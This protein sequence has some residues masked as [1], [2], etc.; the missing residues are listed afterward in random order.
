MDSSQT[1]VH[2]I[3]QFESLE[4][5]LLELRTQLFPEPPGPVHEPFLAVGVELDSSRL[6]LRAAKVQQVI[7][8]VFWEPLPDSPGWVLGVFRYHGRTRPLIDLGQRLHGRGSPLSPS[9]VIIVTK[10]PE[11]VGLLATGVSSLIRVEPEQV[12]APPT[13]VSYAPFM[14][15]SVNTGA[16]EIMHILSIPHLR[17]ELAIGLGSL[18]V[19]EQA[20]ERAES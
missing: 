13:E 5:Q 15:G 17:N 14:T 10:Q 11:S 6:L 4:R 2:L 18:E 1:R 12:T 16:G 3:R 7:P 20:A 8:L 9:M 19:H